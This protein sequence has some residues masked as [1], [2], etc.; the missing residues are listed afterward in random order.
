MH[1]IHVPLP[2][3][4]FPE[5]LVMATCTCGWRSVPLNM[6]WAGKLAENHVDMHRVNHR[7]A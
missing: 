1:Q 5:R 7:Y 3:P 2:E 4:R 6:L